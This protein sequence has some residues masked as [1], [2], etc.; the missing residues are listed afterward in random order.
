MMDLVIRNGVVLVDDTLGEGLDV[1][2]AS[3]R[4][5]RIAPT[6]GAVPGSGRAIDATGCYVLPGFIDLHTHGIGDVRVEYGDVIRFAEIGA[7]F[8]LTGCTPTFFLSPAKTIAS[9]KRVLQ[10]TDGLKACPSVLGL[11]LEGPYV[12]KTGAGNLE[13]LSPISESTTQEIYGA[14]RGK[15]KIWDVSPELENATEFIKWAT[16]R[17]IVTSMAHTSAMVDQTQRAIDAGLSLVTHFY[18][19]FDLAVQTDPG[20][21]PAGLTDYIQ[22]EDRLT[23][24][25]VPDGVHVHPYLVE[26]TL[27]CKGLERVVFVTD[28]QMGAGFPPGVYTVPN[29]GM[30][31]ITADRGARRTTDDALSGSTL[32]QLQSFR[33]AVKLFGKTVPQAS[34]LCSRTPAEVLGLERKG[35]LAE[36]MD[37]DIVVLDKDFNVRYTIVGGQIVYKGES[38]G[39]SDSS[40]KES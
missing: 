29:R 33:N 28:S 4:V 24:E 13:D 17:G 40:L 26:K 27:R 12:A 19:T 30:I 1:S 11:R 14:A 39:K 37:A 23:V 38:F 31:E 35:Y 34:R 22:I 18:D 16:D 10:E 21:Y 25:I 20:V 5:E 7:S 32:T 8:G 6:T 36:G 9:L 3:G 2:V 15:I